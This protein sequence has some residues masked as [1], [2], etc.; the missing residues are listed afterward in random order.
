MDMEAV[1]VTLHSTSNTVKSAMSMV[2]AED[3]TV[4]C[5]V[6]YVVV[7]Y[8]KGK[9]EHTVKTTS[10]NLKNGMDTSMNKYM[11]ADSKQLGIY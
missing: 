7:V 10:V 1:A 3:S 9:E 4:E 11:A 2:D 8:K 5:T 6:L